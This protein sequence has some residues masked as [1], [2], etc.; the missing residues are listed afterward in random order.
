MP[1]P[2]PSCQRVQELT[3]DP[4]NSRMRNVI[5]CVCAKCSLSISEEILHMWSMKQLQ[6]PTASIDKVVRNFRNPENTIARPSINEK[7]RVWFKLAKYFDFSYLQSEVWTF[8]FM[9]FYS[10]GTDWH[11]LCDRP[12]P[13]WNSNRF[14]LFMRRPGLWLLCRSCYKL[15]SLPYLPRRWG[16]QMELF[17]P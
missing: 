16:Y 14:E 3:N 5:L 7:K 8:I 15:P 4:S 9:I 12:R 1:L 17:V 10:F 11:C 2:N 6:V 13:P